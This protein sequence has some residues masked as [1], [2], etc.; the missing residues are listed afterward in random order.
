MFSSD[1]LYTLNG[2]WAELES[3]V[4]TT[5]SSLDT[6]HKNRVDF[7]LLAAQQPTAYY[8]T[9]YNYG[10]SLREKENC[11]FCQTLVYRLEVVAKIRKTETCFSILVFTH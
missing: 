8:R 7:P 1:F 10:I 6:I 2:R 3:L 11:Y 5:I 9:N 4:V